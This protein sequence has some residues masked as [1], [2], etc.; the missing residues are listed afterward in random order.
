MDQESL[1]LDRWQGSLELDRWINQ[2]WNWT[3]RWIKQVTVSL[4][5]DRW[6]KRVWNWMGG[7][8]K[9]RTRQVDRVSLELD[10][11]IE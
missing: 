8:S 5:L 7:S 3:A 1:E 10:R 6:I 9:S 4:E 2:V 11:W